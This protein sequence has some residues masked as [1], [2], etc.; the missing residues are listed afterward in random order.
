MPD[1]SVERVRLKNTLR[2][3]QGLN[4][5]DMAT[6]PDVPAAMVYPDAPFDWHM[7]F[8]E[9]LSKHRFIVWLLVAF[10]HTASAQA[11]MDDYLASSGS[12]SVRAAIEEDPLFEVVALKSY[13]VTT[14]AD[15]A[16]LYLTAELVVETP[17]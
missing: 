17:G 16:V 3:I 4:V 1:L 11:Q 10:T 2:D 6:Q 8:G 13:G 5:Q 7:T 12:K 9:D 14:M 15:G